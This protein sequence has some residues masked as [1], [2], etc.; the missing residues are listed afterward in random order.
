MPGSTFA[1]HGTQR[2]EALDLA[3]GI[4]VVLMMISHG[5][6]ALVGMSAIPALGL[7]PVHLVTKFSSSLFILVFGATLG[8]AFLPSVG[9]E[10]WPRKRRKLLLRGL[11]VFACYKA[12]T[13]VEMFGDYTPD[14]VRAA[15]LY[16]AFPVY[17]EILG[18]YAIALLWVPFAMPPWKRL[19]ATLKIAVPF[20]LALL[21][22]WLY[23]NF[24]FWGNDALQALL[25]EHDEHYTWGQLSR[26][27]LIFVG[28][29]IGERLR[30]S[31]VEGSRAV[32]ELGLGLGL[33]SLA[34][35]AAFVS[36]SVPGLAGHL[37]EVA[38]NHGK[39]PPATGFMLFSLAGAFAVLGLSLAG[40]KGT[41]AMLRPFKTIGRYSLR[42]FI[43]HIVVIF[44]LYRYWLGLWRN[45]S[46]PQALFLAVLLVP[47]AVLWLNFSDWLSSFWR[48][49]SRSGKARAL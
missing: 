40:S 13:V 41:A 5:V 39:H 4:A 44:V 3:R 34:F 23:W 49:P 6:V 31:A 9:A 16:R 19:P 25:V 15:L 7:V 29:L 2:M 37:Q 28:L 14:Q 43:F 30:E 1:A 46:Y 8:F 48:F 21:A 33:L 36:M 22:H 45:I 12:L 18:F 26:G 11:I 17:V 24:G 42:S 10:D 32:R 35:A 38:K 47:S 20:A 27:P